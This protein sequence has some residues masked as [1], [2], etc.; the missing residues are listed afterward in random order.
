MWVVLDTSTSAGEVPAHFF[1]RRKLRSSDTKSL[2]PGRC[3]LFQAQQDHKTP[4]CL[5]EALQPECKGRKQSGNRGRKRGRQKPTVQ[6]EYSQI[7]LLYKSLLSTWQWPAPG[8]PCWFH[9]HML[10]WETAAESVALSWTRK[11]TKCSSQSI[12][13]STLKKLHLG[14]GILWSEFFFSCEILCFMFRVKNTPVVAI[15]PSN[16]MQLTTSGKRNLSRLN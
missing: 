12:S 7:H 9:V 13:Q 8:L 5:R 16:V 6:W 2:D 10:T 14:G 1:K 15:R 3:I 11:F 4:L